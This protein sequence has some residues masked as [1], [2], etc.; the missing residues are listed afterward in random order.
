VYRELD[1]LEYGLAKYR[2][3]FMSAE[4]A[5]RCLRTFRARCLSPEFRHYAMQ[6]V[7]NEP[8][9]NDQTR[10][11]VSEAVEWATDRSRDVVADPPVAAPGLLAPAAPSP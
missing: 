5:Y 7:T 9:Y 11:V 8:G 6:C 2:I 4:N 3:G 10:L 1:N